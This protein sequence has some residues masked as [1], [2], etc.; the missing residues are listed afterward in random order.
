[1]YT[2]FIHST[3][4]HDL[5]LN[6]TINYTIYGDCEWV[7]SNLMMNKASWQT[8]VSIMIIVVGASRLFIEIVELFQV[9]L[10]LSIASRVKF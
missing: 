6:G 10:L 4:I 7:A 1:M 9:A 8:T 2:F 3:T 5:I